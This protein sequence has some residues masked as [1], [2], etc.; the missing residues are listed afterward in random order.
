[1]RNKIETLFILLVFILLIGGLSFFVYSMKSNTDDWIDFQVNL[2]NKVY[3]IEK[4]QTSFCR[5]NGYVTVDRERRYGHFKCYRF[6]G[7]GVEKDIEY[8]GWIAYD[9]NV[10]NYTNLRETIQKVKEK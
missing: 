1:M 5:D 9:N 6:L 4:D 8:S 10:R 2:I 7:T 3:E